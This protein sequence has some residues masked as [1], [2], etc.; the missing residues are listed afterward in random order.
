MVDSFQVEI[1]ASN[2]NLLT[3]KLAYMGLKMNQRTNPFDLIRSDKANQERERKKLG[4]IKVVATKVTT[5]FD[6]NHAGYNT[7]ER[8]D[9][10]PICSIKMLT[11]TVSTADGRDIPITYCL[12]HRIT[13]P[14]P[15]A[16][17][18][19]SK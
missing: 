1:S 18:N 4:K 19:L 3:C 16:T 2:A 14:L 17:P 9:I 13:L 10:C 11:A 15:L 12:Q 7:L 6:P 5:T 8:L